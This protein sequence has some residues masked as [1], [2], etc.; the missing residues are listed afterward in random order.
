MFKLKRITL[1]N[2][3]LVVIITLSMLIR[4]YNYESL[5]GFG[6][7]QGRDAWKV[8]DVLQGKWPAQGPRT[9]IGD[10]YLGAA[11]YYILAPFYILT[12]GDPVASL[13][14]NALVH[15]IT[16][17]LIYLVIRKLFNTPSALFAVFLYSFNAYLISKNITPWNVSYIVGTTFLIF[18]SLIK[19]LQGE[20]RYVYLTAT[21]TGFFFHV[22]FTAIFLIPIIGVTILFTRDKKTALLT[23]FKALPLF[24]VWLIPNI[25]FDITHQGSDSA[26]VNKFFTEYYHGFSFRFMLYRATDSLLM[27]NNLLYYPFL[28]LAKFLIP[29]LAIAISLF[30]ESNPKHRTTILATIPWLIIPLVGFTTYS[31]PISDY[32]YLITLPVAMIL[33]IYLQNKLIAINPK[34]V[35]PVLSILWAIYAWHNTQG[36][37]TNPRQ[38]GLT[39]SKEHVRTYMKVNMEFPYKEGD[40]NSYLYT[41]W[42]EQAEADLPQTINSALLVHPIRGAAL[43]L[44]GRDLKAS[45]AG[46][47]Y[48]TKESGVRATWLWTYSALNDPKLTEL[49]KSDI[50]NH[51]HGIFFEIDKQSAEEMGIGYKGKGPWYASDGLFL[52]SYDTWERKQIIDKT[53]NKFKDVFGHHP[54]SVG[55]WWIGAESI[56]YMKSNYGISAVLQCADQFATD[57]YSIWGTPWSIAYQPSKRNAGIPSQGTFDNSGVAIVQ[58]APRDPLKAYGPDVANSTFSAQDYEYKSYTNEYLLKLKDTYSQQKG[59]AFVFGLESGFEPSVY[60]SAIYD[61][62]ISLRNRQVEHPVRFQTMYDYAQG[63][64]YQNHVLQPTASGVYDEYQGTDEAYWYHSPYYRLLVHRTG[65]QISIV[66]L[67]DYSQ[68]GKEEFFNHPNNQHLIRIN[69]NAV[70]DSIRFPHQKW[71]I[72]QSSETLR[73]VKRGDHTELFA[74]QTKLMTLNDRQITIHTN[75]SPDNP[76]FQQHNASYTYNVQPLQTIPNNSIQLHTLQSQQLFQHDLQ[77]FWQWATF[78]KRNAAQAIGITLLIITILVVMFIKVNKKVTI[79]F[80]LLIATLMYTQ[81]Y[82]L[83][84]YS[85][86]ITPSESR[87]IT[88][89]QHNNIS[90]VHVITSPEDHQYRGTQPLFLQSPA[91]IQHILNTKVTNEKVE[92]HRN[93]S[94]PQTDVVII[95]RYLGFDIGDEAMQQKGYAKVLDE[96]TMVIY[97]KNK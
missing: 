57:A 91:V 8:R 88:Y 94:N 51:D 81:K 65:D 22:H 9:G 96:S 70:I 10:F 41:L 54:G 35:I 40:I 20:Y 61:R 82:L 79:A 50:P 59:D 30:K 31:G 68:T 62:V 73:E 56:N 75:Q 29:P 93:F 38:G 60:Q 97:Q 78:R 43:G 87:A 47:I 15:F 27:L 32:Y 19:V 63:F 89:I 6:W 12:N 23:S 37:I 58:W 36:W 26:R 25:I 52:T 72:A 95:P 80:F 44:E 69:T 85:I 74:G 64:L 53:F 55:A 49:A 45:L 66:D 39:A 5:Q 33:L 21:L 28:Q 90:S 71:T 24:L 18:F 16:L 92:L 67:R 7:D 84:N 11:H 42:K 14:H 48:A 77:Q 34:Y 3:L 17:I 4:F 46:Q 2:I 76:S 13:F 86:T 1:P 83:K